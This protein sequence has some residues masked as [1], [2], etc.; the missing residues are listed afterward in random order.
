LT[1]QY[2]GER[3]PDNCALVGQIATSPVS[4]SL[5]AHKAIGKLPVGARWVGVVSNCKMKRSNYFLTQRHEVRLKEAAMKAR[6]WS[7]RGI[8]LLVVCCFASAGAWSDEISGPGVSVSPTDLSFGIPT[9]TTP[10]VSAAQS[11]TVNITGNGNVTFTSVSTAAPFTVGGTSCTGT[12]A[13]PNT[14]TVSVTFASSSTTLQTGVL[15]ITSSATPGTLSVPLNGAFG[16]IELFGALNINPSLFSGTTWP[17]SAGKP[18]KSVPLSLSC[19]ASPTALLSSTPDGASNVFQDNTIQ[20]TTAIGNNTPVITSNV[21]RNGDP[22]FGG[23]TGFPAGTTNCFQSAYENA[24]STYL[25]QNP[26]LAV[27]PQP[28]GG[29]GS[30]VATYGVPA[31]NIASLLTAGS[32]QT[33]TVELDDA[34]GDLG[35]AT[36]HLVTNCTVAGVAPGGAI[37]GNPINSADP[38]SQTQTNT[39]DSAGGQNASFTTSV[40]TGEQA[41]TV[42]IPNGTTQVTTDFAIPQ[43]LFSQLVAGTSAGPAVCLRLT[44]EKDSSGKEMCKGFLVQCWDPHHT[45]LS[46]DNCVPTASTARNLFDAA[47]FDSPD[48]PSGSN[49]LGSAC[50]AATAVNC[51]TTTLTGAPPMLIGP[52]VLLGGDHWLCAPGADL[53]S[54]PNQQLDTTT[55]TSPASYSATNCVLTGSLLNDLCPLD[56]L[57][58]FLGAADPT[59]GSTTTGKNSLFIPVMNM[60]LPFT[61][62]SIPARN[63]NG[64]VNS[65]TVNVQFIS[66]QATYNSM[67]NP[68]ANGFVPAPP[69]S[70]TYGVAAAASPIP[71]TTYP[72]AGDQTIL[73]PGG[74]NSNFGPPVCSTGTPT[75]FTSNVPLNESTG[76]YNLH[77]FTTDC[78]LT[79]ELLFSAKS[80]TDPTVNWASFR[81]LAFGVDTTAPS[82]MCTLSPSTPTGTNGWYRSSVSANCNASDD[83]SGFGSGAA[84]PN[85]TPPVTQGSLTESFTVVP[86]GGSIPVQTVTDLAGNVSSPQGPFV[87]P[88]DQTAPTITAKFSVSGTTFNVGQTVTVKYT[89]G[90]TGSGVF[91]CGPTAAPSCPSAPAIG[92]ATFTTGTITVDTSVGAVGPHTVNA[93]DCAGNTSAVPVTYTV[94]YGSAD[95]VIATLPNPFAKVKKGTNL[96]YKTFVL[97]FG[98]NTANNVVVTNTI[99]NGTT[100]V[101]TPT[102]GTVTCT[103]AGCSDIASGTPCSVNPSRTV[104]TCTTPTVLPIIKFTGFVVKLVVTVNGTVNPVKDTAS[105]SASNPDP[106]TANNTFTV[107]TTVN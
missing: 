105:V 70:V 20:V 101:G 91:T 57:T 87:T 106:H 40:S 11:V 60:P 100:L 99:P 53:S 104:V 38:S 2:E 5:G 59:H 34:G 67:G 41:G 62:T 37:T 3:M 48:A 79:E 81:T 43:D 35:A 63:S 93:V 17:S 12:I 44:A 18:V 16:S 39:F 88:V 50:V 84:V 42:S 97:N 74:A 21:C 77:Y 31:L 25:G 27:A 89:C 94:V 46:G 33:V 82:L 92:S 55:L 73:N 58:Q 85:T 96:T 66:N 23:Y 103:L 56:T 30:F 76:I 86:V 80:L 36:L 26:D 19:P 32:T 6:E 1:E 69:Y 29:P 64:W 71:D 13:A 52:G 107:S 9:G 54:C 78:A 15:T 102:S 68:S 61:Q 98:P 8:A 72:V 51:A 28:G 75:T 47:A 65:G 45:S 4:L 83:L 49:F 90:D 95:L 10:A 7:P 24:A 22:G 14:C